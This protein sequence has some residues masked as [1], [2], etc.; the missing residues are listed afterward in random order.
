[1][2]ELL[3]FGD[4]EPEDELSFMDELLVFGDRKS[5]KKLKLIKNKMLGLMSSIL[6]ELPPFS[7]AAVAAIVTLS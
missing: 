5:G 1:M 7:R 2:D 4:L 3:V 6:L